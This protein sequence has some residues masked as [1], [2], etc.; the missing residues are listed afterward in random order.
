LLLRGE[1]LK[2]QKDGAAESGW[3]TGSNPLLEAKSD[4][5]IMNNHEPFPE[6]EGA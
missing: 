5:A 4:V 1:A 2:L 3:V 6:D